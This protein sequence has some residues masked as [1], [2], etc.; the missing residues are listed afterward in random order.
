MEVIQVRRLNRAVLSILLILAVTLSVTAF[1]L[2]DQAASETTLGGN[3]TQAPRITVAA[4]DSSAA[5]RASADYLCDGVNDQQEIQAAL[6]ALPA[7]GGEVVLT[8]G[9]FLCTKS[10]AMPPKTALIGQDARETTIELNNSI[11][12]LRHENTSL[13]NLSVSGYRYDWKHRWDAPVFIT[14][15]NVSIRDVTGT[16]DNTVHAVFFV[17]SLDATDDGKVIENIEFSGCRAQD[18]GTFGFMLSASQAATNKLIRNVTF[19]DC[20]AINCGRYSRYD[21]WVAGFNFAEQN[22]IENLQVIRCRAEGSW[23][24]GF[25]VESPRNKTNVVMIDCTSNENAQKEKTGVAQTVFGAG[26]LVNGDMRLVNCTSEG[27]YV[28][29]Y[30]SGG[31]FEVINCIDRSSLFGYTLTNLTD[32]EGTRLTSCSATGEL[33]PIFFGR[34]DMVDVTLDRLTISLDNESSEKAGITVT[35][36]V[37]SA[38][39]ILVQDS[40]IQGYRYGINN[41]AMGAVRVINVDVSGAAVDF[42]NCEV[43]DGPK[44]V[45][46]APMLFREVILQFDHVFPGSAPG[47]NW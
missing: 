34:G 3:A 17:V 47:K 33:H 42:I 8:E 29:F 20:E 16:A 28:G 44:P 21:P 43:L 46:V 40:H 13:Q 36:D 4:S 18:P 23:E 30:C 32:P 1:Y 35:R 11:I 39:E 15:S 10:V 27:N 37:R 12:H 24:S 25:H 5:A 45:P 41:T 14:A 6:D 7:A 9:K 19:I 26:Y 22:D 2:G 38:P 31:G